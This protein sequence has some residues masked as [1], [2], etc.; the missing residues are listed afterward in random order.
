MRPKSA[1][2]E[3]AFDAYDV[4]ADL[5]RKSQLVPAKH[6]HYLLLSKSGYAKSAHGYAE[7]RPEIHLMHFE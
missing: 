3:K 1:G 6:R 7:N 2:L 4:I 5:E